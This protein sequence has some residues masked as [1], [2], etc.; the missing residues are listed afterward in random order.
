MQ[1][2]QNCRNIEEAMSWT[3]YIS[4]LYLYLGLSIMLWATYAI[5]RDR[6]LFPHSS[7]MLMLLS[8]LLAFFGFYLFIRSV[9]SGLRY[10][11]GTCGPEGCTYA[12]PIIFALDEILFALL[13]PLVVFILISA[14]LMV[15]M[16]RP[17]IQTSG[18]ACLVLAEGLL[19]LFLIIGGYPALKIFGPVFL[20]ATLLLLVINRHYGTIL[21]VMAV[22][23]L[24][25]ILFW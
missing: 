2:N 9:G 13:L 5:S 11:T 24:Y 7:G 3:L 17:G 15:L 21:S 14:L 10:G 4:N 23:Y 12:Q 22:M 8:S 20:V 6:K 25:P 16:G 18:G 1:R 19:F